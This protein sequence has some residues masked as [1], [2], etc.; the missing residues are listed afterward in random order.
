MATTSLT[1]TTR[2][3]EI[4]KNGMFYST[5]GFRTVSE[6]AIYVDSSGG[7]IVADFIDAGTLKAIDI[8]GVTIKGSSISGTNI[9]GGTIQGST[10]KFGGDGTYGTLAGTKYTQ[11]S[12][13]FNAG[14]FTGDALIALVEGRVRLGAGSG[15]ST[16]SSAPTAL[17]DVDS[18]L[19]A[20]RIHGVNN[21]ML[22]DTNWN[23]TFITANAK[24]SLTLDSKGSARM[25]YA[26]SDGN[27]KYSIMIYKNGCTISVGTNQLQ[28]RPDGIGLWINNQGFSNLKW[29]A[30]NGHQCLVG[31]N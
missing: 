16:G 5:D 1:S 25:G 18:Q 7:H 28:I 30:I 19:K 9:T 15:A 13:T 23:D 2:G 22:G 4:N 27:V 10:I 6:A 24:T 17:V 8:E 11:D 29:Q 14:M 3:I 12:K 31:T 21:I 26:D 20:V